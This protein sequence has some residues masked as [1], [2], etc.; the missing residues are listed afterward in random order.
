M[1]GTWMFL[2]VVTGLMVGGG[3]AWIVARSRGGTALVTA[4]ERMRAAEARSEALETRLTAAE[5]EVVRLREA[6]QQEGALRAAAEERNAPI[7]KMEAELAERREEASRLQARVSELETRLEAERTQAAKQLSLLDEAQTRLSD[8]F[9]SLSAEALQK[10]NQSF[11][12]LAQENLKHFQEGAKGDLETRKKAI[13][14]LVKPLQESLEKVNARIGEVERERTNAYATLTEQVKSLATTQ[15]Q[16]QAETSHLVTALRSPVVRG[17]WG[18]IQLQ[19]VVEMAGMVAH[20][21]FVQQESVNTEDGRLRPDM[22]I[23]LPNNKNIV[24]DSKTPL[25]GYIDALNATDETERLNQLKRHARHVREHI[26]QLSA[27]AYWDQFDQTPEFV[28]LFLPGEMFFSAALE[29]DPSLIEGGVNQ[30]VILATPTT[31]IALLK[32]VAYGWKQEEL[33]ENAEV[34]SKLG[35]DLYD[36]IR[37]L[38]GHFENVRKGLDRATSAYNKAVGTLET[39]VL[40]TARRF[41]DLGA[42]TGEEI[43]TVEGLDTTTRALQAEELTGG[44]EKPADEAGA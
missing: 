12:E 44:N 41:N 42:A 6:L 1:D 4:A 15:N 19:R 24:V 13:D 22:V 35:R 5:A 34:I 11:L 25:A 14:A 2:G 16:L 7:P 17:R 20:C 43:G 32:A 23:T 36:R 31:L 26:G 10:N 30:K 21:D 9:K 3:A 29:Q 40:V 38:A 27:K 33:A 18:E 37:V 28:V 8:A 39:R